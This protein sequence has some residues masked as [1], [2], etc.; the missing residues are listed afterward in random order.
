MVSWLG[1]K[2][3][4]SKGSA[5]ARVLVPSP[6]GT[7]HE[8]QLLLL[9]HIFVVF[10]PAWRYIKSQNFCQ[11]QQW[12]GHLKYSMDHS[13]LIKHK[14]NH[15][16]N[17][18]VSMNSVPTSIDNAAKKKAPFGGTKQ[19]FL[20]SSVHEACVK[21][22]MSIIPITPISHDVHQHDDDR[23]PLIWP[24]SGMTSYS[25]QLGTGQQQEGCRMPSVSDEDCSH[26]VSSLLMGMFSNNWCHR[27]AQG[28]SETL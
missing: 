11:P 6:G 5:Q 15:H 20:F 28:G 2:E 3:A 13:W 16:E 12:G 18:G 27:Y 7:S 14:N 23:A 8:S 21:Q 9:K 26:P 10:V 17:F 22:L 25:Q 24:N 4:S 1:M 19:N